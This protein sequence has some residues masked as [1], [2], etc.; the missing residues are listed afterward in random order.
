MG[1]FGTGLPAW[2]RLRLRPLAAGRTKK[3]A[4]ERRF[5]SETSLTG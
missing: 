4:P 2:A 3:A 1:P 5:M